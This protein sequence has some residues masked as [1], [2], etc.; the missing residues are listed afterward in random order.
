[1]FTLCARVIAGLVAVML[2]PAFAVRAF[3]N[4]LIRYQDESPNIGAFADALTMHV[5]DDVDEAI[6]QSRTAA[7]V[8]LSAV[9]SAVFEPLTYHSTPLPYTP[10]LPCSAHLYHKCHVVKAAR[11]QSELTWVFGMSHGKT[12]SGLAP[13]FVSFRCSLIVRVPAYSPDFTCSQA[14]AAARPAPLGIVH[15]PSCRFVL[16]TC[17]SC[18]NAAAGS[19]E[20]VTRFKLLAC[21]PHFACLPA[22]TRICQRLRRALIRS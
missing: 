3:C 9:H 11:R 7:R 1:M 18:V 16:Q 4:L 17:H 5:D 13:D 21:P 19:L 6:R 22:R 14:A 2:L 15:A 20:C 10:C 12:M 8:S